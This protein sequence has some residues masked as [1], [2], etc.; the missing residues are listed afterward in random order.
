MQDF[1]TWLL[2]ELEDRGWNNSELARQAEIS[3]P[4]VSLVIGGQRQ[5]GPEFCLKVARALKEP[6]EKVFRLAGIIPTLPGSEDDMKLDE[7]LIVVK[8]LT[9][10]ER[11]DVLRYARFRYQ[12]QQRPGNKP[13]TN[14][15]NTD[16]EQ[17][18]LV[19]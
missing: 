3:Q 6:P 5:P 9:P 2:G 14:P 8:R 17:T 15:A 7:L 19:S 11:E 12:E 1:V 10:S 4:T 13:Q 18:G 16:E